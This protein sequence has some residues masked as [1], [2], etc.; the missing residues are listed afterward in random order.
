MKILKFNEKYLPEVPFGNEDKYIK[1][2]KSEFISVIDNFYN[3][4]D[5]IKEYLIFNKIKYKHFNVEEKN[6]YEIMLM[7]IKSN[8]LTIYIDHIDESG[9]EYN[10]NLDNFLKFYNNYDMHISTHKYNM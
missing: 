1:L 8:K 9:Y 3:I 4:I 10:I 6:K 5:V 7:S 2:S